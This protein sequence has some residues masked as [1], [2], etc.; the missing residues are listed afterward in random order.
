M[1]TILPI[2]LLALAIP[3]HAEDAAPPAKKPV[4]DVVFCL[5]STG[6]MGGLIEGA[7]QKIWSIA[8]GIIAAAKEV[9]LSIPLVVRLEGNNVEAGKKTLSSSGLALISADDLTDAANKI[10]AA[11]AAA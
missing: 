6:S 2:A 4:V 11:V 10:V 1:K 3:L 5:D 7:K 8:N 9:G